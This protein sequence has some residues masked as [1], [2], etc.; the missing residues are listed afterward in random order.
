M[1]DSRAKNIS[2][3]ELN[4]RV[5]K[6]VSLALEKHPNFKLDNIELSFLPDPGI[7]GYRLRDG[8]LD[9]FKASELSDFANVLTADLG[10]FTRGAN[11]VVLIH[12]GGATM[13][14]FPP[15]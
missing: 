5:K 8:M 15:R 1:I 10:D 3:D 6:S 11:P 14:Y 4:E 2:I 13:G 7:I 9:Q 12:N